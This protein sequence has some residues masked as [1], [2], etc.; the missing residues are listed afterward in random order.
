MRLALS[1]IA[2]TFVSVLFLAGFTVV[3]LAPTRVAQPEFVPG[4][5]IVIEIGRFK[6]EAIVDE[7]KKIYKGPHLSFGQSKII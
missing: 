7:P 4:Q 1:V 5:R 3:A 6:I 2:A